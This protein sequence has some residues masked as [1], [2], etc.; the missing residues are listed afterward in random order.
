[1]R[2]LPFNQADLF[3]QGHDLWKAVKA[4]VDALGRRKGERADVAD[5]KA[6]LLLPEGSNKGQVGQVVRAGLADA[7]FTDVVDLTAATT[8][9]AIGTVLR[10]S[11]LLVAD[12]SAPS[13]WDLY[14][15]AHTLFMP[16]IRLSQ[17]NG[18]SP[19]DTIPHLLRGYTAGYQDDLVQWSQPAELE[20]AV[21]ERA[22]ALREIGDPIDGLDVGRAF[23][24]RRR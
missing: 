11:R 5:D 4:W 9:V 10:Q 13:L 22:T 1:M 21:A 18:A 3:V 7:G 14:G 20:K 12:V 8:D 19:L 17:G 2:Y 16:T 6:V 24:E 23:F 15:T